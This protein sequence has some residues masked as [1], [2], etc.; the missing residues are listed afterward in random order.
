[1]TNA[2]GTTARRAR[3]KRLQ[4]KVELPG[5]ERKAI[6]GA[7]APRVAK[8]HQLIQVTVRIRG[9]KP[10]AKDARAL[11]H[12][13]TKLPAKRKYLTREEFTRRYGGDA[14][15]LAK[16]DAFAHEHGLTVVRSSAAHRSVTLSGAVE[17]F[18]RAFGVKL[19]MFRS[20]RMCYRGRTGSIFIPKK[21][22]PDPFSFRRSLHRIHFHSEEA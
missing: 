17:A 7:K 16:V 20:G 8:D 11:M 19:R 4:T 22:A 14:A 9:R 12:M 10:S 21:L 13:G 3:L 2:Q 6:A 1:M 15:D 5:S 18:S